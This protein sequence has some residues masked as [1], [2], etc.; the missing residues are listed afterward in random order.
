MVKRTGPT[1]QYLKDLIQDLRT[2]SLE[3]H[4]PIWK[5]IA[6]K[7]SSSRRR[8]IEV[9]LA[10]IERHSEKND[11]IIVPGVVLS[12]GELSK[13]LKIAAWKFSDSARKKIEKS[14]GQA[15]EINELLKENPKGSKVKIIG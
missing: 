11:T 12:N 13:P 14:K 15:I 7:L 9:N 10:D 2:K 3:L 8:R 5:R 4:A 6:A 1:N